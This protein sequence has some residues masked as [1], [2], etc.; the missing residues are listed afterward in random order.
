M[1]TEECEE[2]GAPKDTC[3]ACEGEG[4]ILEGEAEVYGQWKCCAQCGGTG[5]GMRYESAHRAHYRA[6]ILRDA[7]KELTARVRDLLFAEMHGVTTTQDAW[8]DVLRKAA[9]TLEEA[10][11]D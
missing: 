11:N 4:A 10:S 9:L 5:V 7:L 1:A 8:A 6:V 2:C 3:D